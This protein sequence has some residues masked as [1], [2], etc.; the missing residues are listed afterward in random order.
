MTVSESSIVVQS[1]RTASRVVDGQTIVIVI[2]DQRLHTLNSVGTFVWCRAEQK[3][4]V[5]DVVADLVAEYEVPRDRATHDVLEF[6]REL[7]RLGALEIVE[8]A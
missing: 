6:A 1:P 5:V 3:V 4:R 2:D 7:V 8:D